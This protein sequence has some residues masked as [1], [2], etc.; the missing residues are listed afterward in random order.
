MT[1]HDDETLDWTTDAVVRDSPDVESIATGTKVGN[2]LSVNLATRTHV[3][4][5]TNRALAFFVYVA[6]GLMILALVTLVLSVVVKAPRWISASVGIGGTVF[7]IGL[8][9]Y[10]TRESLT[11]APSPSDVD[12][13]TQAERRPRHTA[14]H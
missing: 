6:A 10:R 14:E 8:G 9:T 1:E 7:A 12:V 5:P 3:G 13:R 4:T 2:L 11:A